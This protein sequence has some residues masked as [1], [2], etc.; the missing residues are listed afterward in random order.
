[1]RENGE[2][3]KEKDTVFKNGLMVLDMKDNGKK[4]KHMV[5]VSFSM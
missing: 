4:I 3:I 5:K 1:M 2:E